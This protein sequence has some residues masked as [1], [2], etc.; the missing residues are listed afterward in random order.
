MIM[1]MWRWELNGLEVTLFSV[2]N[3]VFKM[4]YRTGLGMG[5]DRLECM[6]ERKEVARRLSGQKGVWAK[7][8]FWRTLQ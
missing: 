6:D 4:Y 3:L 1:G 7:L 8:V 5:W 2:S